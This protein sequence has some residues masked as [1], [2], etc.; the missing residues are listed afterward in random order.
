LSLITVPYC[1]LAKRNVLPGAL[2]YSQL[3]TANRTDPSSKTITQNS[4]YWVAIFPILKL[5]AIASAGF[6]AFAGL[7]ADPAH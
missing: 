1:S 2:S 6:E 5:Q 7:R 4:Q 3:L